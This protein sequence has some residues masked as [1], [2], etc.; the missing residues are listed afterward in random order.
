MMQLSLVVVAVVV[1]ILVSDVMLDVTVNLTATG[2]E[3]SVTFAAVAKDR[4]EEMLQ[5]RKCNHRNGSDL[6]A[7]GE[8]WLDLKQQLQQQMMEQD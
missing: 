7:R 5:Q 4:M 2:D 8:S 6:V 3:E 1:V